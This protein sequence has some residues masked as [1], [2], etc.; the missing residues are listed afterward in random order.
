MG[1][2]R[3][4]GKVLKS[5]NDTPLLE[6]LIKR[7][8]KCK[9]IDK[10]I[11]AT[12]KSPKD[13]V[14]ADFCEKKKYSYFRGPENDVLARYYL[15]AQDFP[16]KH[17]VRITADCPLMDSQI[18]DKVVN[19]HIEGDY[20]YTSN[21]LP[22][23][24]PDGM[25]V[26]VFKATSLKKAYK[27]AELPSEREHV[28]PYMRK[29]Q[30]GYKTQNLK[31]EIDRSHIRLTVDTAEDFTLISKIINHFSEIKNDYHLDDVLS[32]LKENK[33]LTQINKMYKRN[34]GSLKSQKEDKIYLKNKE[35][36]K[37]G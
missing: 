25:D 2:S 8:T 32:F 27:E 11:I 16:A 7:L 22:P 26:E 29:Y 30:N 6:H 24:F 3:L 23:T 34:E 33:E 31:G 19:L 1:S 9:T 20:D 10:I 13:D 36:V 4:P 37:N 28:T 18:L 35:S 17:Y 21:I 14:I 15:A 12:T 5:V